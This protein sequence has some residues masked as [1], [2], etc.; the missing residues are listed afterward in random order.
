MPVAHASISGQSRQSPLGKEPLGDDPLG[1]PEP[2]AFQV[3]AVPRAE[4]DPV[5]PGPT[6]R[7]SW[8]MPLGSAG[9]RC[10]AMSPIGPLLNSPWS[11]PARPGEGGS[12]LRQG[13]NR[14]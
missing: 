6:A 1:E 12:A 11:G 2:A 9:S 14:T 5:V 3:A 8:A 4:E 10:L 13:A 7:L